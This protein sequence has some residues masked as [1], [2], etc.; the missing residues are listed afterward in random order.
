ML[1][2]LIR[3]IECENQPKTEGIKIWNNK[4]LFHI[5]GGDISNYFWF[6]ADGKK[7]FQIS[8]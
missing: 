8:W 6:L 3:K 7:D 5:L 1:N 4:D 2:Y